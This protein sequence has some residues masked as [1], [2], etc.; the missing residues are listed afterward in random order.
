MR[1]N[2]ES[3]LCYAGG[4]CS[5]DKTNKELSLVLSWKNSCQE[6]SCLRW[7]CKLNNS[8]KDR[9]EASTLVED[10]WLAGVRGHIGHVIAAALE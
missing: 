3:I 5:S 9:L 6:A 2:H 8:G 10:S 1:H 7:N 4:A